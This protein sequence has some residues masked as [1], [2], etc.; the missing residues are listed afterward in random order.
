METTRNIIMGYIGFF[1][2][3]AVMMLTI[4][5]FAGLASDMSVFHNMIRSLTSPMALKFI[6]MFVTF[7]YSILVTI[8]LVTNKK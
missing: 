5:L 2:A 6:W 4:S 7:V 8:L 1:I 3:M